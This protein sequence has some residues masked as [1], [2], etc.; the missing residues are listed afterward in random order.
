MKNVNFT[1]DVHKEGNTFTLVSVRVT[2]NDNQSGKALTSKRSFNDQFG[3]VDALFTGIQTA[4]VD[5]VQ[6][7]LA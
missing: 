1:T 6:S 4:V 2:I 3:T 5:V 7:T